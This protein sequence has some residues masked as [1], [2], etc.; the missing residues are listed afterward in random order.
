MVFI[1]GAIKVL[2]FALCAGVVV[3]VVILVPLTIYTIPYALW[4]G[5][6]NTRGKHKDKKGEKFFRSV[7]N[8]T[9]LYKSWIT[10]TEPTF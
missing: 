10:H 4:V 7:R 3:T 1:W 8:A 6:Q 2:I 9:R 5:S